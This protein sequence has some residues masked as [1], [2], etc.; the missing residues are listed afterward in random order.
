MIVQ[1]IFL[2]SI[3]FIFYAYLGYPLILII[4][5]F[6]R[7][8]PVIKGD[9]TP[10][11]TFI[12]TAYN[13]EDRIQEKIENTL[14]QDYPKE[15]LEI[16]IASDCSADR[17]DEIVKSYE[18]WG[19]RLVRSPERKGKEA[20]QKLAVEIASGEILVFSDVATILPPDGISNIVK[21]FGD[22]TIGSVS[23]V[24]RFIEPDGT[25]SGE[26]VYVR[27][28]MF[29]RRLET[30]I[31]TLVGLSG[32]FFAA[33][34]KVCQNWAVDLQSDFNTLLNTVRMGLRGV[35]DPESIGYYKNIANERKEFERKVR[36]V[37]RGIAVFKKSLSMLN[38]FR[39]G[40]FSLQLF[41]HKLCRWLVPFAMILAF[42]SNLFLIF[43]SA[44]YLY[45]FSVQ[46]LFYAI[47]FGGMWTNLFSGGN[48]LRVPSFLLLVNLSILNAWYLYVRG[49]RIVIWDPSRR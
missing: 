6:F 13:E 2:F 30:K 29:L 41:S 21:N 9:F 11:V 32:S 43:H 40:L 18:S 33:R 10:D 1:I 36:T 28:E 4:L 37:L 26:G 47:A 22:P 15:K 23:S 20:A 25:I 42:F 7:N 19:I 3:F 39:C 24:D 8:R 34:R 14:R 44:L 12:I 35:L 5:S 16:I 17:T 38:P 31:N 45:I 46:I 48:I 27:Y 49:K